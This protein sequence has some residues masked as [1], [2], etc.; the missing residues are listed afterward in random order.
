MSDFESTPSSG[1]VI[2]AG[3]FRWLCY[4]TL[5]R[6][7][8][9]VVSLRKGH[10]LVTAGPY[11]VVHHPS[12]TALYI[13]LIGLIILHGSSD[14]WLRASGVSQIPGVT[15]FVITWIAVYT[16][17]VVGV[18]RRMKRED[19]M[20]HSTFGKE[21]EEWAGRVKYMLIPGVY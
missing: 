15:S 6:Q 2:S 16:A 18:A 10:Q 7:F 3:F 13:S 9:F 20:M 4:R 11:A 19:R 14:S 17:V 21:W 8:T 1:V 12:Y 5:G